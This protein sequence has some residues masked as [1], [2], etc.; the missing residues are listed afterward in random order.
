MLKYLFDNKKESLSLYNKIKSSKKKINQSISYKEH[1]LTCISSIG[2]LGGCFLISTFIFQLITFFITTPDSTKAFIIA[3]LLLL[4]FCSSF[5]LISPMSRFF[6]KRFLKNKS[7]LFTKYFNII[8][9]EPPF[10]KNNTSITN[11]I[12]DS[13]SNLTKREKSFLINLPNEFLIFDSLSVSFFESYLKNKN[14][15]SE[16]IE[17]KD[18]LIEILNIKKDNVHTTE[19]KSVFDSFILQIY[20]IVDLASENANDLSIVSR[21]LIIKNI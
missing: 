14:N 20:S 17:H 1:F 21:N 11:N 4:S 5:L 7:L 8:K 9:T 2:M 10:S 19:Y 3:T 18:Y 12:N 15:K 16:I 6:K 13:L